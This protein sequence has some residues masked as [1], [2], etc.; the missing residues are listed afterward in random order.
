MMVISRGAVAWLL[1]Y[2]LAMAALV[3]LVFV[4]RQ[5]V[6]E[7]L[8]SPAAQAQWQAWKKQAAK[9]QADPQHSVSRRPPKSNEPP[10]LILMRDYFPAVL[11]M[12][13]LGG[14][15]LFGF[16]ALVVRSM[17]RTVAPASRR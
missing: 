11:G 1:A 10:G 7:S 16:I 12:A 3:W 6:V 5:R 13:L 14:T 17:Q 9:Q 2:L 8:G 4:A 15:V